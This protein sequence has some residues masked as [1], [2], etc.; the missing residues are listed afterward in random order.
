M[1]YSQSGVSLA[2]PEVHDGLVDYIL[3][4]GELF[5]AAGLKRTGASPEVWAPAFL[6]AY[7]EDLILLAALVKHP[8]FKAEEER[9]LF[10]KLNEGEHD[11]LEFRP[12]RT[13]LARH[14]QID[15][16][17]NDDRYERMPITRI[18]VGPGP[19]QQVNKIAVG[20]LLKKYRYEGITAELSA[21]PYRT[22]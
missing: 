17:K 20:D 6:N 12:R 1:T 5:Y 2:S 18:I 21:V 10:T 3:G 13:L 14:L 22:P 9:R 11:V 19:A 8:K 7:A 16:R 15:L 4:Q